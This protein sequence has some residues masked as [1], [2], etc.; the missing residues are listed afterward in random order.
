ML[1]EPLS[2]FLS[3]ADTSPSGLKFLVWVKDHLR[4]KRVQRQQA[5]RSHPLRAR[6]AGG[7]A[8]ELPAASVAAR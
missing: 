3:N 7:V 6:L 1:G 5:A 2:L 4:Q 8:V